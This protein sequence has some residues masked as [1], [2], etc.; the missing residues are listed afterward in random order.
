MIIFPNAKIN[1]GLYV[2]SKRPDNYHNIETCFYPIPWNDALEIVESDQLQFDQTG[3]AIPG[4]EKDNLCLKAYEL[5]KRKYHIPPVHIHLH[6]VIPM[7]AGLGGG[8]SDAAHTLKLLN[9]LFDLLIPNEELEVI[10]GE[11][12]S[13]CPFFI[14]N[15]PMLA[16]GTGTELS[17]THVD[18]SGQY[19]A[20]HFPSIHVSTALA[21]SRLKPKPLKEEIEVVLASPSDWRNRLANDFEASVFEQHPKIAEIKERFYERGAWYASMSGS[22]SAVYGLFEKKPTFQADFIG[23]L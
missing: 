11:I 9:E 8:S 16:S 13:D 23:Q 22:G 3:L 14:Q 21:Y 20:I 19:L 1:L 12:G 15:E 10:A 5:L 6:K 4:A 2:V 17:A 18:L 7:G